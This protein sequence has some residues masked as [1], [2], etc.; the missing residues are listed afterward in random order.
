MPPK[1]YEQ[2]VFSK[3]VYPR[4]PVTMMP[5]HKNAPK[6]FD[7]KF[8]TYDYKDMITTGKHGS[9]AEAQRP[10][11]FKPDHIEKV[12]TK[13]KYVTLKGKSSVPLHLINDVNSELFQR[14]LNVDK[15]IEMVANK[16][17]PTPRD[18][19]HIR[20]DLIGNS[21]AS[22]ISSRRIMDDTIS[23]V[24]TDWS[25]KNSR[26]Y[27]V[28]QDKIVEEKVKPKPVRLHE[29]PEWLKSE[30]LRDKLASTIKF[31]GKASFH[32]TPKRREYDIHL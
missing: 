18:R 4:N 25:S 12:Q 19:D 17:N 22:D 8:L 16:A 15:E 2:M 9:L 14:S 32:K 31:M 28:R 27:G 21:K 5:E 7:G 30:Q 13:K 23:D 11:V 26:V 1:K 24:G 20:T 3:D 6:Y 10:V 29:E